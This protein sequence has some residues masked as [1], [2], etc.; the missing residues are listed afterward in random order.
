[1]N[2]LILGEMV[3]HISVGQVRSHAVIRHGKKEKRQ[4]V[5]I[6]MG[7]DHRVLDGATCARFTSTWKELSEHPKTAFLQM[8]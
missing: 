4:L 3:S 5:N 6:V 7:A 1:M 8:I 2:P